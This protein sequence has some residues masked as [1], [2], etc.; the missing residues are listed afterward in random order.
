M[1][2]V[3]LV[4]RIIGVYPGRREDDVDEARGAEGG[5]G[6]GHLQLR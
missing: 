6:H 3:T 2:T 5:R 4:S 1:A